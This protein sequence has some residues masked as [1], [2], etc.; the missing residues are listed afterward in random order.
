MILSKMY[1][2]ALVKYQLRKNKVEIWVNWYLTDVT[3]TYL[4]F[5]RYNRY[6]INICKYLLNF[7][8]IG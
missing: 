6:F 5:N 8:D 3:N 4:I 2:L 7:K 1:R